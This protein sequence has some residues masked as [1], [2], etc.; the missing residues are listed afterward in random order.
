MSWVVEV[1]DEFVV[2]RLRLWRL[3]IWWFLVWVD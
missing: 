2:F 1:G 3:G